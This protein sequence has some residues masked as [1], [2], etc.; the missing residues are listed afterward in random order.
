MDKDILRE[1][2]Y[3]FAVQIIMIARQIQSKNNEFIISRQI[4]KSG[5]SIGANIEEAIGGHS[6]KDFAAKLSIAYKEARETRYWLSLSRD[7]DLLDNKTANDLLG[8]NN[9]ICKILGKII[10]TTKKRHLTI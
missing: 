9:E 3:H 7:T 8:L 5:T 10:S 1:K 6:I 4:L 2:S